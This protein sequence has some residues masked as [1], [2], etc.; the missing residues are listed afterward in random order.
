M[1]LHIS[2]LNNCCEILIFHKHVSHVNAFNVKW[3]QKLRNTF[4]FCTIRH[5]LILIIM[6]RMPNKK[7]LNCEF[8]WFFFQWLIDWLI[9][10][11]LFIWIWPLSLFCCTFPGDHSDQS[12]NPEDKDLLN[13]FCALVLC[14]LCLWLSHKTFVMFM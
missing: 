11:Y 8:I 4:T 2:H 6:Y 10:I 13:R 14:L 9:D 7:L 1:L 5:V 12:S 3:M